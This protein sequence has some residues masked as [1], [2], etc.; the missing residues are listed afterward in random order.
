MET[1]CVFD[2][3]VSDAKLV[4]IVRLSAGKNILL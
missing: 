2:A 4:F 1:S 3:M